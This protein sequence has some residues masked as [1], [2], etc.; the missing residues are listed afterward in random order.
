M[1]NGQASRERDEPSSAARALQVRPHRVG[2]FDLVLAQ[3]QRL[4]V[5]ERVAN[6]GA[7]GSVGYRL[8]DLIGI[9]ERVEDRMGVG[10]LGIEVTESAAHFGAEAS[11]KAYRWNA[12]LYGADCETRSV[13]LRRA[14]T[15]FTS[16]S[17]RP[18][19]ARRMRSRDLTGRT[20]R[21]LSRHT[22]CRRRRSSR[23][24][25]PR[26]FDVPRLACPRALH[27]D[28]LFP[29]QRRRSAP[30]DLLALL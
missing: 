23:C 3:V 11:E 24:R 19:G 20:A 28:G 15:G 13:T 5:D 29:L 27:P 8:P 22:K 25:H 6:D 12:A 18:R 10:L 16:L 7:L 14:C 21:A 26:R 1:I 2:R 9:E 30:F 17:P 4:R